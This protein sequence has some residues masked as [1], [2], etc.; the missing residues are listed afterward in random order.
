MP[1]EPDVPDADLAFSTAAEL[2]GMLSA[3]RLSSRELVTYFLDRLERLGPQLNAL[4]VV[5]RDKALEGADRADQALGGRRRPTLAGVPYG[6]KDMIGTAAAPTSNGSRLPDPGNLKSDA[7]VVS[8]LAA[9]RAVL[10]A[11]LA[12]QEFGGLHCS[13]PARSTAGACRNPWDLACWAGGSSSGSGAAVAAGLVPFAL[14]AESGGSIAFPSSYCG[15]TG[16]RPTFGRVS[17][18]GSS[19]TC[20][21]LDKIGPMAHSAGDCRVIFERLAEDVS[22]PDATPPS[23]AAGDGLRGLRFGFAES[24]IED[25]AWDEIRP[26][27]RDG[28]QALRDLGAELVPTSLPTGIP[29]G[30]AT[31]L[32]A[33]AEAAAVMEPVVRS[34]GF[35]SLTL[36]QR[37]GM[38]ESRRILARDY[39]DAQRIRGVLRAKMHDVF[40]GIDAIVSFVTPWPAP[41]IADPMRPVPI[42]TGNTG[43]IMVGN[44]LGLPAIF[45]PVGTT[46]RGLPVGIQVVGPPYADESLLSIGETF[47]TA[48]SWHRARPRG[49]DRKP[50]PSAV[51]SSAGVP[52]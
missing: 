8:K 5:T 27:L 52:R 24:D 34:D 47:Q 33:M 51:P 46:S 12:M 15:V 35:S 29:Y 37:A 30:P 17:R 6:V 28:I 3:G 50:V 38:L 31:S 21:T 43:L 26:P 7:R 42:T 22:S 2:S 49:F 4:A 9:D 25:V 41:P 23:R 44:L 36:E 20:W 11:K 40:R 48:T 32:I 19:I 18:A 1:A 14:G 45:L 13:D 10:V 39:L 16:F